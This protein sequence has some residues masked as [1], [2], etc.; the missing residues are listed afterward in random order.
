MQF[1][2]ERRV[3]VWLAVVYLGSNIV[4]NSLNFYWFGKMLEAFRKRF[5]PTEREKVEAIDEKGRR[6]KKETGSEDGEL[7]FE[8]FT[9]EL[10]GG[11]GEIVSEDRV[12][13]EVDGDGK[14]T[15]EVERRE[16]RRRGRRA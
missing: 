14:T 3:P 11:N 4:L 1:A 15:V 8:G 16:V 7:G 6:L 12:K 5:R 9:E 10:K 2:G 13:K